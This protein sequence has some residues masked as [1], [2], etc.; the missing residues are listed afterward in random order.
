[1]VSAAEL[2]SERWYVVY[3]Q[4]HRETTA[5][6]HLNNQSFCTFMPLLATTIRHARRREMVLAPLFQRYLFVAL[7]VSRDG[8]RAINS[9]YGVSSL[10]MQNERPSPAQSGVV[11]TLIASSTADGEVLFCQ[12]LVPGDHVRLISGPFAGQLGI[13]RRLN[14]AE[15]V[16]VLLAIMGGHIPAELHARSVA[17]ANL[18][19]VGR[20]TAWP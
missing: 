3:T 17:P 9:T 1:M 15:R 8:W 10:I 5:E 2:R 11:E 12:N 4:P 13:L 14:G 19:S 6:R 20:A 18:P 16:Q 7:D